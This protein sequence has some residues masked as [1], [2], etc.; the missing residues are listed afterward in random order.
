MHYIFESIFVGIYTLIIYKTN[1]KNNI[2]VIGFI[3]HF[4]GYLFN[5]HTLYCKYGY[6]CNKLNIDQK[7]TI[8]QISLNKIIIECV[9]EGILFISINNILSHVIKNKSLLV[10]CIGF[11]LHIICEIIGIHKLFC[12]RC[13]I[14]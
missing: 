5:L 4:F 13:K 14:I 11:I 12:N 9:F 8:S 6:A 10:F 1:N 3:K 2:F 7:Y